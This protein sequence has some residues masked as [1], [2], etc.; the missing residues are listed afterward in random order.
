VV[1]NNSLLFPTASLNISGADYTPIEDMNITKEYELCQAICDDLKTKAE[2]FRADRLGKSSTPT[3]QG[4]ILFQMVIFFLFFS[5]IVFCLDYFFTHMV[6]NYF[7]TTIMSGPNFSSQVY[8]LD[9]LEYGIA[10]PDGTPRSSV[11]TRSL[12]KRIR[13]LDKKSIS[14]DKSTYVN[15]PVSVV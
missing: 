11:F 4:C 5:T 10:R 7:S 13:D 12:I 2:M 15:L 14:A 1:A 8:Y 3:T 6:S 9:N